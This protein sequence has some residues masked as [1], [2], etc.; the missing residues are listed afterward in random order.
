MGWEAL[1]QWGADAARVERLTG[2]VANDV[3]S[4]R[5]DGRRAVGRLGTRSD[6]D[7][8]WETE[9]LRHLDSAGLTVP[10]PIPT[11]DGRL[12]ADG[13]VVM[14]YLEGGPPETP[15]DWSRVADTL[16][17]LHRLTRGWPQRPGW[18]SSTDLLHAETGTKID[19]GA[20]PAEG[21]ARCRAAWARL[22]GRRTCVVHGDTN[23]GNIRMTASRV[24]LIDWD[25]AHVDV[26]DL[27]LVLPDN[28]A[29]LDDGAYDIAAQA[30][31]AWEAAVCWD[32]DYAVKRLGEVRPV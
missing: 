15:A 11:S 23:P 29:G 22:V 7:L 24:A 8:A 25:E 20:M 26:P 27:D 13:L 3:W 28:A 10:V 5:V 12:F 18:R 21:V 1:G 6:A 31:A 14:T 32:D 19:L 30:S 16:R 2:G 4:V 9:L 17:E